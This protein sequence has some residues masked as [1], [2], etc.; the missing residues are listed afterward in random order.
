MRYFCKFLHHIVQPRLSALQLVREIIQHTRRQAHRRRLL[1]TA[2]DTV[3]VELNRRGPGL[4]LSDHQTDNTGTQTPQY[5]ILGTRS[6][7]DFG[8]LEI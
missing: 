8:I 1:S 2:P 6:V 4:S 5:L 3:A 7:F